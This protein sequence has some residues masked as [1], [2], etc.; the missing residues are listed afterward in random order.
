MSEHEIPVP[1]SEPRTRWSEVSGGIGAATAY[2]R[3]F[4]ELAAKG[5]DVHGEASFVQSLLV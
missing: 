3:R 5:L 2:Q 4:D 1:E